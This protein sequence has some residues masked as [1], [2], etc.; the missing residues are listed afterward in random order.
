M[1]E[2]QTDNV[3]LRISIAELRR[4]VADLTKTV[5]V[6]SR[7][8]VEGNGHDSI[9]TRL[10]ILEETVGTAAVALKDLTKVWEARAAEDSKG[11]WQLITSVISGLIA[12]GS[13][14]V[15]AMFALH[16]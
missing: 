6:L 7:H 15:T 1:P 12:L 14:V 8:V 9:L 10:R 16:K 2:D 5:S 11:K 13:A 4:D 3:S